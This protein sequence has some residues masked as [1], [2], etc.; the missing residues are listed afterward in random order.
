V[1]KFIVAGLTLLFWA[2]FSYA[3]AATQEQDKKGGGGPFIAS[4]CLGPR[5]GLELNEGQKI[6]NVEWIKAASY[7]PYVGGVFGLVYIGWAGSD[8][9]KAAGPGGC[10]ANVCIGPR[11]GDELPQRKI[12]TK[13]WLTL[14]PIVG[15]VPRLLISIEALNGQTMTQIEEEEK[16]K[17]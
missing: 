7:A 12:R 11:V 4:C 14:I 9:W 10:L 15:I 17:K 3:A 16:L 8:G 13:E 5:V 6:R 2:Q 1:K